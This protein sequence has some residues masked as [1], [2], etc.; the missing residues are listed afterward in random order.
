VTPETLLKEADR[1]VKC[2]LC[3]PHC[4]TY[5]KWASEADSP[6]GRISL[7]QALAAGELS[8]SPA[9]A[10]HLDRCLNCLACEAACP[11]GV[12]YGELID[13]GRYLLNQQ[14]PARRR[15]R[16]LF[17]LLSDRRRLARWRGGYAWLRRLGLN[18]LTS[19]IPTARWQRLAQLGQQLSD[20][21]RPV[22]GLHAAG[23]PS[24]R[25]VQLFIG[26]VSSQTEQSLIR[27]AIALLSQLG[28]AVEIPEQQACCGAIHRHNGYPEQAD[29]LCRENQ[30]LLQRSRAEALITLA[31]ACHLELTQHL[32][33]PLPVTSLVDFLLD[34]NPAAIPALQPLTQRVA[35]HRPCSG[36]EDRSRELLARIP[37]IELI[38]LP[39]NHLCCG[40]AG[41]YLLTQPEAS[42]DFGLAK[43][44][45]LRASGCRL[46]ITSNTGCALQFRELIREA[47]LEMEVLHPIELLRR[48]L[49]KA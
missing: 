31:T 28:F 36:P 15:W 45:P 3:L 10:T 41:S 23:Q 6:R 8:D 49:K 21:S 47:G 20:D 42:R 4:P 11:S 9:L 33:S 44:E 32:D 12:R 40:A 13:G 26:C 5:L 43:I 35:L 29:A 48:Q 37:Q 7:I 46:L 22:T 27:E 34:L 39:A 30:E 1:C 19:L 38:D 17:D 16:R 2:G 18:R 25:L 24:G 14:Q